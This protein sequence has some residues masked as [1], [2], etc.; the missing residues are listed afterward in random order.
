MEKKGQVQT[1]EHHVNVLV[2]TV[3]SSN[4]HYSHLNKYVD[5]ME[6]LKDEEI[7]D[8]WRKRKDIDELALAKNWIMRQEGYATSNCIDETLNID[9]N[10]IVA[11]KKR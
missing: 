2:E 6:V 9:Y 3:N 1:N 10:S 8:L 4:Q 5:V 7:I 11:Y